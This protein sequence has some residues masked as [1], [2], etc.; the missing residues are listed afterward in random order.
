VVEEERMQEARAR[1]ICLM[2]DGRFKNAASI[3]S[4]VLA[5][6]GGETGA[7]LEHDCARAATGKTQG[8]FLDSENLKSLDL[9]DRDH[10]RLLTVEAFVAYSQGRQVEAKAHLKAAL[11]FDP[12]FAVA[13]NALG[14]HLLYVERRPDAAKEP[15]S[16]AVALTPNSI[17]PS[18]DLVAI[19]ADSRRFHA[20][21]AMSREVLR[22]HRDSIRA[23]AAALSSAILAL[24]YSGAP[25]A[26]VLALVTFLPYLGPISILAWTFLSLLIPYL[27]RRVDGR[28]PVSTGTML[29]VVLPA[30]FLRWLTIGRIWP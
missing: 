18:L 17:G 23:W 28:L 22:E 6:E 11:R 13:W 16:R 19:E 29:F 12:Q 26:V 27:L 1:A 8:L 30:Y 9:P 4:N 10:S 14:R 25:L 21:F 2:V 5:S 3:L 7:K 24:P 15:L 20:A